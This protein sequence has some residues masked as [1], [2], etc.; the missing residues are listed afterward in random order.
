MLQVCRVNGQQRGSPAC[1][2]RR[3]TQREDLMMK[4][5]RLLRA[6]VLLL[7]PAL[8]PSPLV[9]AP[10]NASASGTEFHV[11]ETLSCNDPAFCGNL[12]LIDLHGQAQVNAPG[13]GSGQITQHAIGH[14]S[15]PVT[16]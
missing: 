4:G 2:A 13:S 1:P 3:T 10:A 9:G 11:V 7:S 6:T 16:G 12:N 5:K 14:A 8:P 15:C